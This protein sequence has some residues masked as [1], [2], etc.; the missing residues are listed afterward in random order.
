MATQD[1]GPMDLPEPLFPTWE[2]EAELNQAIGMVAFQLGTS[3][4]SAFAMM[5]AHALAQATSLGSVVV[6]VRERR[7]VFSYDEWVE[8]GAGPR[9]LSAT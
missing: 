1:D 6:E 7:L 8:A 4:D 9:D 3:P 5:R 2:E